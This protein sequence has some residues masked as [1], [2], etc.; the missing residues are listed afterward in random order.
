MVLSYEQSESKKVFESNCPN[1]NKIM[2][3][4]EGALNVCKEFVSNNLQKFIP[5]LVLSIKKLDSKQL[6][7]L[8]DLISPTELINRNTLKPQTYKFCSS[9]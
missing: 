3:T 1:Y 4:F 5:S 2:L 6:I 7:A 8:K 9:K